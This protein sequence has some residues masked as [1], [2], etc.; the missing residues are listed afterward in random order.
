MMTTRRVLFVV[1]LCTFSLLIVGCG[2]S[3][4]KV[5]R[6]SGQVLIDGE[7]VA[8]AS[9]QFVPTGARAAQ[10]QTDAQGQFTLTTFEEGDGCAPGV[11]RVVVVAITSTSAT[12]ETLHVP[13]KYMDLE[14]TDL[15][16]T[17]DKPTKDLKIELTWD[18]KK[19]PIT[20]KVDPE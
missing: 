2:P 6:V 12:E 13:E 20:R 4:P 16:V 10:G 9:V 17:I 14:E 3:R 7:P 15:S 8:D 19:G 1:S 11:H 5:V 18:G